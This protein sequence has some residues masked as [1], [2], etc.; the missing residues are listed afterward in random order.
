MFKSTGNNFGGPEISFKDFQ[1]EH[2]IVLNAV[3]DYDSTNEEYRNASQLEIYVP[4]LIFSKSAVAG[5]FFAATTDA[6]PLGTVVKTWIKNRNTIVVEKLTAWDEFASHRVYICTM[7]GLRGFR[8]FEFETVKHLGISLQQSESIGYPSDQIYFETPDWV[9]LN[10]SL[11]DPDW[12]A[13]GKN[14]FLTSYRDF[15]FDIDAILPYVSGMHTYNAPGMNIHQ[16]QLKEGQIHIPPLPNKMSSGTGWDSMFYAFIVRDREDAVDIEG[17]LRWQAAE[18]IADKYTRASSIDIELSSPVA[19][20]TAMM[21]SSYYGQSTYTYEVED[22]PEGMTGFGAFFIGTFIA[23]KCLV[24]QL[25]QLQF[26]KDGDT[27]MFTTT[28]ISGATSLT[29]KLFDTSAA[30]PINE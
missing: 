29:F 15:P 18:L 28:P 20:V 24:L 10:F 25:I 2:E 4:D 21:I 23:G 11:G 7:Y 3:F 17:R 27:D 30:M 1:S 14:C 12:D 16:V 22:V 8:G 26:T 5:C 19:L 13:D 9:F 6:G